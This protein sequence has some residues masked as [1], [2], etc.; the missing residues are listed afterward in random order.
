MTTGNPESASRTTEWRIPRWTIVITV[1][2]LLIAGITVIPH[3]YYGRKI[4]AR[5]DAIR[6]QGLPVTTAELDLWY[7]TPPPGENA[8]DVLVPAFQK[9]A[10]AAADTVA[11]LPIVGTAILPDRNQPLSPEMKAVVAD[12]LGQNAEALGLLAKGAAM[13][14]CRYPT[15]LALGPGALLDHLAQLRQGARLFGLDAALRAEEGDSEG[16]VKATEDGLYLARTLSRE[17]LMISQLVRVSMD[18]IT[19]AGLE[20]S[21]SRTSFTDEQLAALSSALVVANGEETLAR[22]FAGERACSSWFFQ[23]LSTLGSGY[24]GSLGL[25]AP[26]LYG[27]RMT[28]VWKADWLTCLELQTECVEAARTPLPERLARA[29]AIEARAAGL[30]QLRVVSR[31]TLPSVPAAME[32]DAK[33]TARIRAAR[34]ALAI[35][36]YRLAHG[37]LPDSLTELVPT[38]LDAVPKDP[39][40]GQPLRYRK[41]E[42]GYFVYSVGADLTDDGGKERDPKSPR[43][44]VDVTFVVER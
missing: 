21:L 31:L 10:K 6:A 26:L 18:A 8:A 32:E 40:D 30:P 42:V 9:Y 5:L 17:P 43:T 23:H 29:K 11:K 15:N 2:V 27:Y 16:V 35:E 24:M 25:S 13:E 1:V 37:Q 20:R 3:I 33:H 34:T 22:A 4:Q 39:F 19:I 7:A 12:Y 28:A 14:R 38:Y 36:R 44:A 41:C